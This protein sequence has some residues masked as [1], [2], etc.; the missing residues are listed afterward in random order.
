MQQKDREKELGRRFQAIIMV[1]L[2]LFTSMAAWSFATGTGPSRRWLIPFG[3]L[4]VALGAQLIRCRKEAAE[5]QW[6]QHHAFFGRFAGSEI[7]LYQPIFVAVLGGLWII[8]GIVF[9]IT[10]VAG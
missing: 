4:A 9:V 10:G 1:W 5:L 2:A 6:K 3:C 7:F 8:L